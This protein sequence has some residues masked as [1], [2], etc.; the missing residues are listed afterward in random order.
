MVFAEI[1]MFLLFLLVGLFIIRVAYRKW[2]QAGVVG[3][4]R[5]IEHDEEDA[6]AVRRFK[7]DHPDS[8]ADHS[9]VEK[10]TKGQ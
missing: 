2:R 5:K 9:E 1:F 3:T 7:R 10:F 6:A 4:M 8:G